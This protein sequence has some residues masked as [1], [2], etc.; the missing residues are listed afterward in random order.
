MRNSQLVYIFSVL[1]IL[2]F[3]ACEEEFDP[4][5]GTVESQIVV[6]GFIEIGQDALPTYVLL[7]KS[8]PFYNDISAD[9]L[10]SLFVRDAIVTVEKQGGETVQ[11]TE[12]CL[13]DVPADLRDEVAALLGLDLD[14]SGMAPNICAYVDLQQ[15]IQKEEGGIYNLRVESGDEVLTATTSLP[16][17]VP[18]DSIWFTDPPGEPTD[19]L[20]EMNCRIT[21]PASAKNFYR[22]LTAV[23]SRPL[24][25]GFGSVTDDA[26][27]DGMTF[28]F[29]LQ[30]AE[31]TNDTTEVE[32]GAFGLWERGDT[33]T[34]KWCSID[35]A[36]HDFWLTFE[37]NRNNQGPFSAY[38]RVDFN[39]DGGIGI[40]GGYSVSYYQMVVPFK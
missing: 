24:V 3:T 1:I 23:N 17:H 12:L 26:F 6:E 18:L 11:L 7:T 39:I 38:T 10:D 28:D 14:S 33:A 15:E 5:N 19:T 36:H 9:R 25:S 40:W 27:F 30:K 20:A 34:L 37:F 32:F 2:A 35:Q 13:D 8:F 31:Y 16:H 29:P 21:D 22:Y 4:N